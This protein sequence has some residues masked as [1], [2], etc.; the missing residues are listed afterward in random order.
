MVM[1]IRL[2]SIE[3]LRP[4]QRRYG[5]W[6]TLL[7]SIDGAEI[8]VSNPEILSK[9]Q[10]FLQQRHG[11]V[12]PVLL[13]RHIAQIRVRLCVAGIDGELGL[14][15]AGGFVILAHSPVQIPETKVQV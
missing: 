7:F 3:L 9:L 4:L 15:C 5:L 6:I 13:E 12:E 8:K 2:R 11:R 1:S 14:E 10:C